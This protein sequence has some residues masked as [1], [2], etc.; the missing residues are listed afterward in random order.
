MAHTDEQ[1][2]ETITAGI[3]MLR[4]GGAAA[5]I[6]YVLH[7]ARALNG[8]DHEFSFESYFG[9]AKEGLWDEDVNPDEALR[10]LERLPNTVD[11]GNMLADTGKYLAHDERFVDRGQAVLRR[12][13]TVF[14]EAYSAMSDEPLAVRKTVLLEDYFRV[15]DLQDEAGDR[16]GA[17]QT[18]E[19]IAPHLVAMS[20]E[21]D[22]V[23]QDIDRSMLENSMSLAIA[24]LDGLRTPQAKELFGQITDETIRNRIVRIGLEKIAIDLLLVGRVEDSLAVFVAASTDGPLNCWQRVKE[25]WDRGEHETVRDFIDG[26]DETFPEYFRGDNELVM[27]MTPAIEVLNMAGKDE[28]IQATFQGLIAHDSGTAPLKQFAFSCGVADE[29]H[30]LQSVMSG[31]NLD[32]SLSTQVY[33]AFQA[34]RDKNSVEPTE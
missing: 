28:L 24:H 3:D 33:E 22:P 25:L 10:L 16:A 14:E 4:M 26:L 21:I 2:K 13:A 19:T 27:L 31:L 1:L 6:S 12:T 15:A 17:Q 23:M 20:Q 34:G 32:S 5:S 11:W 9:I 7:Q 18:A 29:G 30:R 8:G